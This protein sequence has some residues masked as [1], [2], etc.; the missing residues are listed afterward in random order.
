MGGTGWT[1]NTVLAWSVH[2]GR[3]WLLAHSTVQRQITG[4]NLNTQSHT[5]TA[6]HNV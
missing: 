2:H 1:E 3:H 5:A 4:Q 6:P